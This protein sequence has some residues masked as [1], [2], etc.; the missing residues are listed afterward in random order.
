[1]PPDD[2]KRLFML[3]HASAFGFVSTLD[4][5]LDGGHTGI[6][7]DVNSRD[8]DGN[9]PLHVAVMAH[10]YQAVLSLVQRGAMINV[11]NNRGETPIHV[12]CGINS[13]VNYQWWDKRRVSWMSKQ[14]KMF[15]MDNAV[16]ILD[17]LLEH[18]ADYSVV[19][20][21]GWTAADI[22]KSNQNGP[23]RLRIINCNLN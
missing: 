14:Q 2:A 9:T 13:S 4:F 16:R 23:L 11:V 15:D 18:N 7:M 17:I 22:V 5:L 12:A 3:H 20:Q 1:M 6:R 19:D 8:P 10:N 21:G